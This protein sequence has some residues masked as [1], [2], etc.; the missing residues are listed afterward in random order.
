MFKRTGV[1]TRL[2]GLAVVLGALVIGAPTAWMANN[3]ATGSASSTQQA[4]QMQVLRVKVRNSADIVY[5]NSIVDVLESRGADYVHVLGNDAVAAMLRLRGFT[6]EVSSLLNSP[7]PALPGD[8]TFYGGYRTVQTHYQHM[9][10]VVA[11]YPSLAVV[12]D[13]GDSYRKQSNIAG[14]YDL[15]TICITRLQPGDCQLNPNASKPRFF[16]MA[17]I[18]ARELSTAELAYRWIDY[19]VDNYDKDPDITALLDHH[20]MW[21]VPVT[22][23]DGRSVVESGVNFYHRKNVNTSNNPGGLPT[24]GETLANHDGIDLNRNA[25]YGWDTP[26]GSSTDACSATYRG[27]RPASEPEEQ[28]LEQLMRNLFRDQRPNDLT[29]PAPLTT[30]GSMLSLHS[31]SNLSLLPWGFTECDAEACPPSKQAPNDQG[32]RAL[33]FR[34]GWYNNY[35]TGQPSEILYA[36]SGTSDDF[37]YGELGVGAG[38]FEI[39]PSAEAVVSTPLERCSGFLPAY[40]CQDEIFWPENRPSFVYAA[41][42]ARQPF[43]LSLGP[44]TLT[45]TL[46]LERV[47]AGQAVTLNALLNDNAYNNRTDSVGRPAV[48]TVVAGE[49]FVDTPPWAGGQAIAMTP[50]DGAWDAATE[51][52]T[53]QIKTDS[54]T[55]GRH[56]LFV[57]GRDADGNYGPVTAHWLF[58]DPSADITTTPPTTVPA[59]ATSTTMPPTAMPPTATPSAT[60]PTTATPLRTTAPTA[61]TTTVVRDQRLFLPLVQR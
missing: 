44:T 14:G 19:L 42:A 8:P 47:V 9:D 36:A 5:L 1:L 4:G 12:H 51:G 7:G 49:V 20:E 32:L 21:V 33:A 37:A 15:K 58:V 56:T 28:A 54:L 46:S 2:L 16:L 24:C 26:G 11:R 10:D 29:S 40:E 61:T 6:V 60:T 59:T 27:P 22:N 17:A 31:S 52:A 18:H 41:K 53:A 39:G 50:Q 45:P 48:Q 23:P 57:R 38:T 35:Q 34:L 55:T 25:S 30:V 43:A 3:A 13:Y